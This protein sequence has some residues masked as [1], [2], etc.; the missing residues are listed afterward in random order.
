M[1]CDFATLLSRKLRPARRVGLGTRTRAG[2]REEGLRRT[3][4]APVPVPAAACLEPSSLARVAGRWIDWPGPAPT[5]PPA[6]WLTAPGLRVASAFCSVV[7]AHPEGTGATSRGAHGRRHLAAGPGLPVCRRKRF[8]KP[9]TAL[10][11]ID[12]RPAPRLQR[13]EESIRWVST[14]TPSLVGDRPSGPGREEEV[15]GVV[16][17]LF[18]TGRSLCCEHARREP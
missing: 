4:V 16:G 18:G 14:T 9:S 7:G 8:P 1:A 2:A 6:R 13:T 12:H 17:S 15:E 11:A 5:Y 10:R 3:E